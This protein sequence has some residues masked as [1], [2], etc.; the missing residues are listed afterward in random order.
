MPGV[1]LGSLETL[2]GMGSVPGQGTRLYPD[3]RF[4]GRAWHGLLLTP[5][6]L[7]LE[8]SFH[9]PHEGV[10]YHRPDGP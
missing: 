4:L 1:S 5:A 8:L 6:F 3:L 2:A 10:Q 7:G 9:H